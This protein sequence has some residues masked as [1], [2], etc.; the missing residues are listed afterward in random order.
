MRYTVKRSFVRIIGSLWMPAITAATQQRIDAY[1]LENMRGEDGAI[2]RESVEHWVMTHS[3]DFSSVID[4]HAD[5]EDGDISVVI[6]WESED[7]EYTYTDCMYGNE[8]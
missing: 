6:D 1:E 2:T 5:I 3:G 8:E 7:S 4:F